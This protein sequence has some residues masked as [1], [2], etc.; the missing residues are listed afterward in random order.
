MKKVNY[1][2]ILN[3]IPIL[4]IIGLIPLIKNDYLLTFTY[5]IIIGVSLAIH[6]EKK[7]SHLFVL[8]FIALTSP[9]FGS[10]IS[11]TCELGRV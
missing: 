9:L 1:I 5:L 6:R 2:I 4:I 8:G 3:F 7:D 10:I 11:T